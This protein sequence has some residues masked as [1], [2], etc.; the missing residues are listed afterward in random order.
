MNNPRFAV[1][2][3]TVDTHTTIKRHFWK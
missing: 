2:R 1:F 3:Q